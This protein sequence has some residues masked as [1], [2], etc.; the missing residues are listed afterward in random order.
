MTTP[1]PYRSLPL[2]HWAVG[3]LLLLPVILRA[4]TDITFT[5]DHLGDDGLSGGYV[6][7]APQYT[8]H[9]Q[10]DGCLYHWKSGSTVLVGREPLGYDTPSGQRDLRVIDDRTILATDGDRTA[11]YRF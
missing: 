1:L 4:D 10:A 7:S 3:L 9:L 5:R 11:V 2:I 8:V 6:V